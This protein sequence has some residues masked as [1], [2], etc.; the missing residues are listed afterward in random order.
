MNFSNLAAKFMNYIPANRFHIPLLIERFNYKNYTE[1]GLCEGS[2]IKYVLENT[3]TCKCI[4]VD[5]YLA[6]GANVC[7][8]DYS[9]EFLEKI[10]VSQEDQDKRQKKCI[11]DL[12]KF[13]DR[14]EFHRLKSFDYGRSLKDESLDVV[15]ID[16]DHSE[17]GV[18]QDL[19]T[20]FPKIKKGGML[21]G[22]DYGGFFGDKQPVVQVK[23]AVDKFCNKY[24]IKYSVTKPNYC[25][26]NECVQS[27]FIY[28]K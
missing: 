17:A 19:E 8:W 1:I 16:G 6:H 4:G 23:P 18:T 26:Q 2:F 10:I 3:K 15:F 27:F 22:H 21:I 12:N 28:K 9:L 25:A 5:P 20:Y 7:G 13:G 24:N 14:F 11:E